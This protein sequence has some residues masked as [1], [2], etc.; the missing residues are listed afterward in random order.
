MK[1]YRMGVYSI[2]RQSRALLLMMVSVAVSLHAV[3][4]R[5]NA[6]RAPRDDLSSALASCC[7][8]ASD[9][10]AISEELCSLQREINACASI[11]LF[12][13][14]MPAVLSINDQVY[15]LAEEV[16]GDITINGDDV[17]L[18]L[19]DHTVNG[20]VIVN[21]V[22][23][24]VRNGTII[25]SDPADDATADSGVLLINGDDAEILNVFVGSLDSTLAGVNGNTAVVINGA[26]ILVQASTL[27]AGNAE[28][29]NGIA[30]GG[31]GLVISG[32]RSRIEDSEVYGGAGS[33][34]N[35]GTITV[36]A[37]GRGFLI[38]LFVEGTEL[39]SS[40]FYAGDAGSMNATND[41]AGVVLSVAGENRNNGTNTIIRGCKI[42]GGNSM[43]IVTTADVGGAAGPVSIAAGIAGLALGG[44]TSSA[45]IQDSDIRG[46]A[47]SGITAVNIGTLN[48]VTQGLSGQGLYVEGQVIL[49]DSLVMGG[50]SGPIVA[51]GII[52]AGAA[53]SFGGNGPGLQATATSTRVLVTNSTIVGSSGSTVSADQIAITSNVTLG[54]GADGINSNTVSLLVYESIIVGGDSSIVTASGANGN[55]GSLA[56][57]LI[58]RQGGNGV[59]V[60]SGGKISQ[61]EN[62]VIRGGNV[63]PISATGDI[64]N[65]TNSPGGFAGTALAIG[66]AS[67][68]TITAQSYVLS[69]ELAGGSG[70]DIT[71]GGTVAAIAAVLAASGGRAIDLFAG[72]SSNVDVDNCTLTSGRG[73]DVLGAV[74]GL[75]RTGGSALS[76]ID[77]RGGAIT[78]IRITENYV[79]GTGRGGNAAGAGGTGGDGGTGINVVAAVVGTELS[80]NTVAYT[81]A[82]GTG[83][84]VGTAG[85]A[86][87]SLSLSAGMIIYGNYAHNIANAT[88]YN[89]LAG[90]IDGAVTGTAY[91]AAAGTNFLFNI[92]Q[93]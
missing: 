93:P 84:V 71:S 15:C 46:G 6:D 66:H 68:A 18:N 11:P 23:A 34:S 28:A 36:G 17:T 13:A 50:P 49:G 52:G 90:N 51:T 21:G 9:L 25:G 65:V 55:I 24:I 37:G 56:G 61:F 83:A 62:C 57:Q 48:T 45:I 64:D 91:A 5:N 14:D 35:D 19:N 12:Q 10:A 40:V 53:V 8:A 3:K 76:A 73:G 42:Y 44:A 80:K 26:N 1:E 47:V 87:N 60:L 67:S 2:G 29:V 85:Q 92:H 74:G 88:P 20:R 22:R 27:Q 58:M 69:C 31:A 70:L 39:L 79:A 32:M 82:G 41:V 38:N 16:T 77:V 81:G 7:T 33:D 59:I 75:A 78:G 63:S 43:D 54:A 4:P 30:S 72:S 89:I 86:I